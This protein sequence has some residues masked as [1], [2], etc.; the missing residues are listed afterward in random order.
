MNILNERPPNYEAIV[1]VIPIVADTEHVIF[2]YFPNVYTPSGLPLPPEK[3]AHEQVHLNQ[4]QEVG[5]DWW[6]EMF[7]TDTL[8]RFN[9]EL[10]AHQADYKQFCKDHKD[11]NQRFDYLQHL[12]R[13]LSGPGYGS[14]AKYEDCLKLIKQ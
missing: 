7:L 13:D 1:K 2:T 9:E 8:F 12:A 5:A 4:Q 6:W 14:V 11:R 10:P 3:V